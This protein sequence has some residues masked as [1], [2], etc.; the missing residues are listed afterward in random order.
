MSERDDKETRLQELLKEARRLDDAFDNAIKAAG[1]PGRW[2]LFGTGDSAWSPAV[3]AAWQA[4]RAAYDAFYAL[5]FG[6][7]GV[8][9]SRG[10]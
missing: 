1:F 2:A 6:D 3:E 9:G 7:K 10:L 8:L 4:K 5:H